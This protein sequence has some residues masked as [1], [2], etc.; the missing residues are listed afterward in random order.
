MRVRVK[1]RVIRSQEQTPSVVI[2][3]SPPATGI[4]ATA[5]RWQSGQDGRTADR[6][7]H[8]G[9]PELPIIEFSKATARTH[10]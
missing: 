9:M 10:R 3:R 8:Q 2:F 6:L 5:G 4:Q 7:S 1:N